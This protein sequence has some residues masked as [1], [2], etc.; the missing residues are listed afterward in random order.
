M[1]GYILVQ[2]KDDELAHGT[3]HGVISLFTTKAKAQ[4]TKGSLYLPHKIIKVEVKNL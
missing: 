4:K 3:D 1:I 2:K